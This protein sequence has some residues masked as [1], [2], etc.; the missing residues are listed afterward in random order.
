MRPPTFA[1][2]FSEQWSAWVLDHGLP[3]LPGPDL[4]VGQSV[5][6]SFWAG[7]SAGAV[8]HVRRVV[9]ERLDEPVI[10]REIDQYVRVEGTWM[11]EMGSGGDWRQV[12]PLARIDVPATYVAFDGKGGGPGVGRPGTKALWGKVGTAAAFGEVRQNGDC[13]RRPLEAPVGLFVVCADYAHP[14]TVRILD[15]HERVLAEIEEPAG[16]QH[17]V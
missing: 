5:P 6:V 3:E 4:A 14:F 8:V 7:P 10:E 1:A 17:L 11:P 2:D 15:A 16:F 12:P 9:D 13:L